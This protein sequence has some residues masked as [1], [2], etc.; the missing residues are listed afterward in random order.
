M[1]RANLPPARTCSQPDQ[2]AIGNRMSSALAIVS[3]TG[4]L[5]RTDARLRLRLHAVTGG[6]C[7]V[8]VTTGVH[9][10]AAAP[11]AS[12]IGSSDAIQGP[13]GVSRS[14]PVHLVFPAAG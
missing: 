9:K 12:A 10:P 13:H 2:A 1:Q 7:E 11:R 6:K 5:R 3:R 14:V 8:F 4:I